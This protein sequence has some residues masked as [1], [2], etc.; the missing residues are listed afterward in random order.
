M[1]NTI[2]DCGPGIGERRAAGDGE[3]GLGAA[4]DDLELEAELVAHPGDEG[5]AVLGEPAGLGGDEPGA[6]RRAGPRSLSRQIRSASRVRSIAPSLRLLPCAE[7]LAE[8]HD[9][10][11]G[12]DDAE[13]EMRRLGDEQAAI[14]GAEVE[15]RI[16]AGRGRGGSARGAAPAGSPPKGTWRA[17]PRP[18][19]P[20]SRRALRPSRRSLPSNPAQHN[21]L[22]P[23]DRRAAARRTRVASG[24]RSCQGRAAGYPAA[25]RRAPSGGGLR[26]RLA[27]RGARAARC[28]APERRGAGRLIDLVEARPQ[29][30]RREGLGDDLVDAE[31]DR[32]VDHVALRLATASG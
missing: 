25:T 23:A 4:V 20:L 2:T 31:R 28:R 9:A 1:S 24:S 5:R 18:R 6:Q 29:H 11:E 32:P 21:P 17:M 13:A 14:V 16:G 26:G 7:A 27:A 30:L 12:I 15:R 10:R 3:I 8:P 19:P 22:P